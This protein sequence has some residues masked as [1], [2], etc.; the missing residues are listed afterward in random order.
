MSQNLLALEYRANGAVHEPQHKYDCTKCKYSWCCGP[1]CQC[2]LPLPVNV[3]HQAH[4]DKLRA[5]WCREK[6]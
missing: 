2:D 4:I 5:Q 3:K 6:L 1:L